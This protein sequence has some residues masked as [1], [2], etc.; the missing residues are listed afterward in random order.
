MEMVILISMNACLVLSVD[1]FGRTCYNWG[2]YG[3]KMKRKLSGG[4]RAICFDKTIFS[5]NSWLCWGETVNPRNTSFGEINTRGIKS[6]RFAGPF[7]KRAWRLRRAN[8]IR[9]RVTGPSPILDC[10]DVF[11]CWNCQS[12][13]PKWAHRTFFFCYRSRCSLRVR[14]QRYGTFTFLPVITV[15]DNNCNGKHPY[16]NNSTNETQL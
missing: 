9:R 12:H 8:R 15:L 16:P 2:C 13:E 7:I 1:L 6:A 5:M 14:H 10:A 4:R 3:L 11:L